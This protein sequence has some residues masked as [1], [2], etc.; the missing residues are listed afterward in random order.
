MTDVIIVV[1]PTERTAIHLDMIFTQVDKDLCVVFPP[2]FVGPE[3]LA[4]YKGYADA[5]EPQTAEAM[6]A[7]ARLIEEWHAVQG[8][9]AKTPKRMGGAAH[10]SGTG[11]VVS[12]HPDEVSRLW[13]AVPWNEELEMFGRIFDR[14]DPQGNKELRD[15][16]F[17]LLWYGRELFL[18]RVPMTTDRTQ[19]QAKLGS[20]VCGAGLHA[21]N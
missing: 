19:T 20:R 21:P 7:L 11:Q 1:L 6:R 2:H 13:D 12:L 9:H 14:I 10:P 18:D 5:A 3:R 17:H 8:E 15:A 4:V 16:A